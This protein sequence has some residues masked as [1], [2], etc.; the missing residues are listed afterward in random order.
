MHGG[1]DVQSQLFTQLKFYNAICED[2]RNYEGHDDEPE[3]E[4]STLL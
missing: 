1:R 4:I 2:E 3:D